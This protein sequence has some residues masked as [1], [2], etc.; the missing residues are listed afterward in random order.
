MSRLDWDNPEAQTETSGRLF[1]A[2]VRFGFYIPDDV[3]PS[4][5]QLK[6]WLLWELSLASEIKHANPLCDHE[7]DV[8]KA[9]LVH[10]TDRGGRHV[11]EWAAAD[12]GG[13]RSGRTRFVR[14]DPAK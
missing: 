6:E 4:A 14:E 11:T 1:E 8:H 7:M 2:E 3:E 5:E 9:E 12:A 10:V 13:R